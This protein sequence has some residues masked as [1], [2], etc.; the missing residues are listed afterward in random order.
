MVRLPTVGSC[1]GPPDVGAIRTKY[2]PS[3]SAKKLLEY[4]LSIVLLLIRMQRIRQ[5]VLVQTRCYSLSEL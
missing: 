4:F 1:G 3:H 5:Q 2:Y